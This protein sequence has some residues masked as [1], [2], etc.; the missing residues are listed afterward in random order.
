MSASAASMSWREL[1]KRARPVPPA[2]AMV[3][4]SVTSPAVVDRPMTYTLFGV[5]APVVVAATKPAAAAMGPLPLSES[6]ESSPSV[7][8]TST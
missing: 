3:L 4:S 7:S 1:A 2:W 6:H 8:W 5:L